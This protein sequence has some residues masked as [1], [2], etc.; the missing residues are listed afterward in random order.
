[1][2]GEC[3]LQHRKQRNSFTDYEEEANLI[4]LCKYSRVL[5]WT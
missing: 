4:K 5:A 1:M 2:I 3:N